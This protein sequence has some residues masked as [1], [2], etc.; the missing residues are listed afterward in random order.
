[1]AHD[2]FL[3]G[4]PYGWERVIEDATG[5]GVGRTHV[6]RWTRF[7]SPP[8]LI[9]L[10]AG[11]AA[12]NA[13]SAL[14]HLALKLVE[15]AFHQQF[16]RRMTE[17]E[18]RGVAFPVSLSPDEFKRALGRNR[19]PHMAATVL[20]LVEG[21]QPYNVANV[22]ADAQLALLSDLDNRDKHRMLTPTV[23]VM[24]IRH[25]NWRPGLDV[26][27]VRWPLLGVRG[28]GAAGSEI[29]R[30]VFDAP[31]R[32]KDTTLEIQFG[33]SLFQQPTWHPAW[34]QIDTMI[35]TVRQVGEQ[36]AQDAALPSDP[37]DP[38]FGAAGPE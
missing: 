18:Q 23:H 27:N 14:D 8:D 5:P 20:D 6:L 9:A 7:A 30:Y 2:Q 16:E 11:D 28:Y 3:G 32:E 10:I 1:M 29:C 15:H 31:E 12:H 26:P 25:V 33:V 35:Q 19:L 21:V 4:E 38:V 37:F 34:W 36:I 22:P 24:D 13:R 17:N